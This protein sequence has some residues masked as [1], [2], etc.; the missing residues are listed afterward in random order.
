MDEVLEGH[1]LGGAV[2]HGDRVLVN[3]VDSGGLL[4]KSRII[5]KFLLVDCLGSVLR[6]LMLLREDRRISVWVGRGCILFG[7]RLFGRRVFCGEGGLLDGNRALNNIGR[8]A[9]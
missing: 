5:L 4:A 9:R 7:W 2:V 8:I 6:C 3:W 1:V